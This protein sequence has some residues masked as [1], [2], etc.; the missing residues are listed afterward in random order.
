M[1]GLYPTLASLADDPQRVLKVPVRHQ[2][3][4]HHIAS[5]A[6]DPQRVL[7]DV[8]HAVEGMEATRGFI[9]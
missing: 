6:D 1:N 9:G 5:L 2:L 7:K 3:V 4:I 8:T